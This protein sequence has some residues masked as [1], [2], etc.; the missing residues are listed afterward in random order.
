MTDEHRAKFS[1]GLA[2]YDLDG[3]LIAWDTQMLL[4]DLVLKHEGWRRA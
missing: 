3:T 2:L 1:R 4:C